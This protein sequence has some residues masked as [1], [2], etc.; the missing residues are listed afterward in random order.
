M[1]H[2]L[3]T[4]PLPLKKKHGNSLG[5]N[6][7]LRHNDALV[8]SNGRFTAIF[9]SDS[10]FVIYEGSRPIWA[11]KTRGDG[12]VELILQTD[13]NLVIYTES[14]APTWN[15]GTYNHGTPGTASLVM[16]DDGN[17]VLY[18]GSTSLWASGTQQEAKKEYHDTLPQGG[19]LQV[20]QKITSNNGKYVAL[21]QYDGN[22]VVYE[23]TTPLWASYTNG[24]GASWVVLQDDGNL[25][26]YNAQN[27][28]KW[29][30]NTYGKATHG[31]L[32]LV[33]QDDANLVVYSGS[34]PLWASAS[35]AHK[36]E[37]K[38]KDTLAEGERLNVN[39]QLTSADGRYRA[40]LQ[41]DGNFVVYGGS[42]L[43]AAST[44]GSGFHL[45]LQNDH[46]LVVYE[47]SSPKW[48]TE[49]YGK[50]SGNVRL[51]MQSDGNLV[52]YDGTGAPLWNSGT[53][54]R[55]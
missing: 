14:K 9:Q 53:C 41:S 13:N 18:S 50:G 2:L 55:Y 36:V 39:E 32:K 44:F 46:N 23:G 43:W 5:P 8:S 35:H 7:V 37:K 49:T 25:V 21:F 27:A 54:G 29:A 26:I 12:S 20:N 3:S 10:N 22:F 38:V 15:T 33:M 28:P 16:Q 24:S 42:A 30:S 40:V 6:G 48:N 4:Q 45:I 47:G 17:L 31:A 19:I 51:V 34:T 52:L 1:W 11:S